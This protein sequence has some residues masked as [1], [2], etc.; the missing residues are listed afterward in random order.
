MSI[1]ETILEDDDFTSSFCQGCPCLRKGTGIRDSFGVPL[2]PDEMYCPISNEIDNPNC[3]R[4]QEWLE[5]KES[6]EALEEQIESVKRN[7]A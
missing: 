4:Y 6:A 5:I 1:A 2:E 3:A 7:A